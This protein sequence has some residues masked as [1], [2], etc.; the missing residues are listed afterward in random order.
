MSNIRDACEC[1]D[2]VSKIP[3]SMQIQIKE[4]SIKS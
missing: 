1:E 3:D 4:H 2:L